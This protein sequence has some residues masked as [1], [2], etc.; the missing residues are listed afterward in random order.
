MYSQVAQP[1]VRVPFAVRNMND[2]ENQYETFNML[3]Q[4]E[5]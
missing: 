1:P 5:R 3:M 2:Q 4:K